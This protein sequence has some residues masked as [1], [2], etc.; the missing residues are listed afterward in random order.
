MHHCITNL[1]YLSTYKLLIGHASWY[2]HKFDT[3]YIAKSG[4]EQF[5]SHI[6]FIYSIFMLENKN[7]KRLC[8]MCINQILRV[9][10]VRQKKG[11][12]KPCLKQYLNV[13]SILQYSFSG[14]IEKKEEDNQ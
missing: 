13:Y 7:N 8:C 11:L 2:F 6:S 14:K 4:L 12:Y 5:M 10:N 3:Q 9:C 1:D